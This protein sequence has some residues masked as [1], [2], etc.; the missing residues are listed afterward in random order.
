MIQKRY[1]IKLNGYSNDVSFD[2]Y[3][4]NDTNDVRHNNALRLTKLNND[5]AIDIHAITDTES[6]SQPLVKK[7]KW[8]IKF[9][10]SRETWVMSQ[11]LFWH[12]ILTYKIRDKN[13]PFYNNDLNQE[14][15]IMSKKKALIFE[16]ELQLWLCVEKKQQFF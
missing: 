2:W 7:Y 5:K 15:C 16:R 11:Q 1:K 8:S 9:G 14:S 10:R 4:K 3:L 12:W 6:V 13:S